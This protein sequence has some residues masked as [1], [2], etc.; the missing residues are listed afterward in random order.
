MQGKQLFNQLKKW[1][2]GIQEKI[3]KFKKAELSD[4]HFKGR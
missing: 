4:I 3:K 2:V 1:E